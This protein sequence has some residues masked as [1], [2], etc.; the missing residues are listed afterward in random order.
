ME[1]KNEIQSWLSKLK[2]NQQN[3]STHDDALSS[4]LLDNQ[5]PGSREKV[6]DAPTAK[7]IDSRPVNSAASAA[8][9][10]D[11]DQPSDEEEDQ[12]SPDQWKRVE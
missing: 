12:E 11:E 5:K 8:A 2:P 7:S 1:M 9:E 6:D 3:Q 4:K 10:Q